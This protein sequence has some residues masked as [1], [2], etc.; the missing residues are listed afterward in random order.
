MVRAISWT[1][2]GWLTPAQIK[3]MAKTKNLKAFP[4]MLWYYMGGLLVM[5]ILGIC[6][7]VK[8]FWEDDHEHDN[9][10]NTSNP[11]NSLLDNENGVYNQN[12]HV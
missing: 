4:D 6:V 5:T 9:N 12:G 1:L 8:V 2:G 3:A 10:Y 11:S 7:Q